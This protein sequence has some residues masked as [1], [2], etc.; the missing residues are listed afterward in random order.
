MTHTFL[1]EVLV[2]EVITTAVREFKIPQ[3]QTDNPQPKD[4]FVIVWSY[5]EDFPTADTYAWSSG[6]LLAWDGDRWKPLVQT[7]AYNPLDPNPNHKIIAL[8]KKD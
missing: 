1:G 7:E 6:K 8:F 2:N 4:R 3:P 5:H